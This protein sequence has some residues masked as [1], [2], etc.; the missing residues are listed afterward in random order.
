MHKSETN[1][2][3]LKKR[4]RELQIRFNLKVFIFVL[5]FCLSGEIDIYLLLMFFAFLHECGHILT[6][7][8]AK[9]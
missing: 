9:I 7:N 1:I 4:G 5:F 3:L 8:Y 6:R 2:K